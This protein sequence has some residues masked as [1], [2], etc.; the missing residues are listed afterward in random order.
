MPQAQMVDHLSGPWRYFGRGWV[1]GLH[2]QKK[3]ASR[4]A[5]AEVGLHLLFCPDPMSPTG[6]LLVSSVQQRYL[7]SVSSVYFKIVTTSLQQNALALSYSFDWQGVADKLLSAQ[8]S[9]AS[10]GTTYLDFR[11][12]VKSN[13][14]TFVKE[15]ILYI[16]GP[17]AIVVVV[18]LVSMV[19]GRHDER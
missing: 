16:M 3:A 10:L 9:V 1:L 5:Q 11:C 15:T 12:L 14:N 4:G 17:V 7:V 18:F 6:R 13:E 2:H 19:T 8:A